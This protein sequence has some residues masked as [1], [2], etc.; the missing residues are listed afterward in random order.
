[1]SG[2][3]A[4]QLGTVLLHHRG[5]DLLAR[6]DAQIE[7][8]AFNARERAQHRQGNLDGR[9]H[10]L[11]LRA[12]ARVVAAHPDTMAL[13]V[14]DGDLREDTERLAGELGLGRHVRFLGWRRDLSRIYADSNVLVVSSDNE[15]TPVAAIEAMAAGCPVVAIRVGGVPDLITDRE[16]GMLV[17]LGDAEQLANALMWSRENQATVRGWAESAR[18]RVVARHGVSALVDA[19]DDLYRRLVS[20]AS[21]N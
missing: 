6:S 14:G 15:G 10:A 3:R 12:L 20:A 11:Y 7:I 1:M 9:N 8:R 4:A 16:T 17:P 13:V 5:Q 21:R 18:Q 2:R 19:V